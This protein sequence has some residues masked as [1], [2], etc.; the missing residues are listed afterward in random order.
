MIKDGLLDNMDERSTWT[1]GALLKSAGLSD[2]DFQA[3]SLGCMRAS[4]PPLS[5]NASLQRE[6]PCEWRP[7]RRRFCAEAHKY[8]VI[9]RS[10]ACTKRRPARCLPLGNQTNLLRI[11]SCLKSSYSQQ[12]VNSLAFAM[13][14]QGSGFSDLTFICG[15]EEFRVHKAVVCMQSAP[16]KAAVQGGFQV[17][18]IERVCCSEILAY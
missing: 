13:L 4:M 11:V 14:T 2:H 7:A 18:H 1:S 17:G 12:A 5:A 15:G 3:Q 10:L 16:I 6:Y 9:P 8:I